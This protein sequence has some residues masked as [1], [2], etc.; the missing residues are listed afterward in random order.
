MKYRN[1]FTAKLKEIVEFCEKRIASKSS[2]KKNA[3]GLGQGEVREVCWAQNLR[4]PL[5][6]LESKHL[7]KF[8]ALGASPASLLTLK[9][10]E[11]RRNGKWKAG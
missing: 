6:N 5:H 4:K 3:I 7:L 9:Y 10:K 1:L 11:Y 8:C 2:Q